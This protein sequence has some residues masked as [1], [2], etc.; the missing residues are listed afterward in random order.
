MHDKYTCL[1]F[2]VH[3]HVWQNQ[4]QKVWESTIMTAGYYK[5]ACKNTAVHLARHYHC[6]LKKS[7]YQTGN[8]R[9]F[10]WYYWYV[11]I[12]KW[13]SSDVVTLWFVLMIKVDL[14][15]FIRDK[16]SICLQFC[17][18]DNYLNNIKNN[19]HGKRP[20]R[21]MKIFYHRPLILFTFFSA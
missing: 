9:K 3:V 4:K 15:Y 21:K 20:Q 1:H 10:D 5:L 14:L 19:L 13:F 18:Q 6:V 11:V 8:Y 17:L 16:E 2:L 12:Y 7:S